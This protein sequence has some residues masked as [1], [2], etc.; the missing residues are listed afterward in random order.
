[1][2]I[3]TEAQTARENMIGSDGWT[4]TD[5]GLGTMNQAPTNIF[6]SANNIAEHAG[7]NAVVGTLSNTDTGGTYGYTLRAGDGDTDNGSFIISDTELQL[8]ASADYEMKAT[9]SVRIN[10]SDG[11]N[12]FC[13]ILRHFCR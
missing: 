12:G 2:Y 6:L 8:K 13:K 10:V 5:G 4:I 3:S 1:M 9:Y 7:A 11:T